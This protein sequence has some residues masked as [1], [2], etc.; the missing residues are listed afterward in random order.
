[1]TSVLFIVEYDLLGF[2]SAFWPLEFHRCHSLWERHY[3]I[4]HN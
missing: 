1:M 3:M 4:Q 2:A